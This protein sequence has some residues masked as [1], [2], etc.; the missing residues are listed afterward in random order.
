MK[1]ATAL[2]V[3]MIFSLPCSSQKA[4]EPSNQAL[5][6]AAQSGDP[7]AEFQL[8]R[9]YEDGNGVPH[10]DDRAAE[11]FHK[12]ADQGNVDAQNSLGLMYAEGRGVQRDRAEAVRWYKKAASHGLAEAMY[13]LAIAYYNGEGT[14][15]NL[16]LAYTW[17]MAAQK[18]GDPQAE[19]AIKD[20]GGQMTNRVDRS[21]FDL[22]ELYE[23]GEELPQD[24]A[25]ALALYQEAAAK[26]PK[27]SPFA[28]PAQVKLCQFYGAGKGAAQDYAQAKMWCLKSA[29]GGSAYSNFLLGRM[30]EQG[31]G[32]AP[33]NLREAVSWYQRAAAEMLPAAY[34]EL[35][36]IRAASASHVDQKRAYFWYCLAQRQRVAGA[37]AKMNEAADHLSNDEINEETNQAIFWHKTNSGYRMQM[38][39]MH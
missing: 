29:N 2:F 19:Q 11:W 36:R 26:D 22:A 23:K 8:G 35:G 28:N 7:K 33:A 17:L 32:G 9:A 6:R 15:G 12:A 20:I 38:A 13:H 4:A 31:T 5:L 24:L 39:M 30:A 1:I 25:A 21:K 14:E 3:G 34:V 27:T 37:E 10:D 18:A 16:G